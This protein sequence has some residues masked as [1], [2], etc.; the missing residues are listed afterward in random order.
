[1]KKSSS[2]GKCSDGLRIGEFTREQQ[3]ARGLKGT[4][5]EESRTMAQFVYVSGASSPKRR[6]GTAKLSAVK[7]QGARQ[8]GGGLLLIGSSIGLNGLLVGGL[9]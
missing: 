6:N 5:S 8:Q 1:L 7:K 4:G 9:R 3:G 2:H